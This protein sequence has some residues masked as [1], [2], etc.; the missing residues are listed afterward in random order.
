[1]NYV[2]VL[3]VAKGKNMFMLS[4]DIGEVL[5]EPTEYIHNKSYFE[6]I[7]SYINKLNIKDNLTVV[8]EATSIYHKSPERFFKENNYHVIVFNPLI[9][10]EITNTIRKT[11]T[12]KQDCIKLTNLFWKGSIP[13]RNYTE[14]EIYTKLN[15][16]SRQY[17]HLDEG[18]NRH[19]NRY[20][21]LI[22]LC[23]PEFE[24]CFKDGKTYDLT[25]LNFIKEFPHAYIIKDKRVD[26]LTSYPGVNKNSKDVDN[27][28]QLAN[29]IINLT[30]QKD[31]VKNQ[32]IE[33]AKETKNFECIN[34]LFDI[35][36]LSASLIIAELK[37]ITR[38]NNIK[39]INASCGLDPTIV[40]SGKS[41]NYHGPIS[42]RG[43]RYAR[44]ILFNCSRNIITL[45]AKCDKENSIYVYYQKKKQEGKHFYACLTACSTKLIRII[46]ALCMNNSQQQ[47]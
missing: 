11:K 18:L 22:Q 42:K 27:L 2:L 23:F 47:N 12:D 10:K 13:D 25:A 1:M 37:D 8:M 19:K 41:I 15:E 45:S 33:L 9:G 26:A 31:E 35:G 32:M 3:D 29:I 30:E 20:K 43:N 44:K 16:L 21:E 46:Y 39:Q 28:K 14:D 36:E 5:L 24:L 34:S 6:K 4:S 17:Y 7:D 38:F 40:Q